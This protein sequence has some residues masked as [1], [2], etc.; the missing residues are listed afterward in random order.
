MSSKEK[1]RLSKGMDRVRQKKFDEALEIFDKVLA[2]D[3]EIPEAW[4]NRGVALFGLGR[5]D[6]ALQS[7]D[8][9]LALDPENLDALRNKAFVLRSQKRLE[10]ALE[11]YDTVL[12]KGGDC[13]DLES[14]AVVLTALGRL[15]EALSC[16][17]LARDQM[18][19]DRLEGEI[20]VVKALMEE[21]GMRVPEMREP[22]G[23][24]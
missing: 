5:P 22:Q 21:R 19:F 17:Y 1:V 12:Q 2:S 15:E 14:T 13:Y 3:P 7:Y 10:E 4:N 6:E 9:S 8:R 24:E 23:K 20:A 16:L 18:L 11:T